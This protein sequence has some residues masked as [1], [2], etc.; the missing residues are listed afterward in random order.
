MSIEH[1]VV[2]C[3]RSCADSCAVA[4]YLHSG[5]EPLYVERVSISVLYDSVKSNYR[6]QCYSLE[7][8][9]PVVVVD[10]YY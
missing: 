3:Y 7:K 8:S 6:L 9:L 4:K 2:F 1:C 5:F 10:T